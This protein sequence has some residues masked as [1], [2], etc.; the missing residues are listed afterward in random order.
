[1]RS[2]AAAHKHNRQLIGKT[3]DEPMLCIDRAC[4]KYTPRTENTLPLVCPF[5]LFDVIFGLFI[6]LGLLF[7]AIFL[8]GLRIFRLFSKNPR[9]LSRHLVRRSPL[10]NPCG[11]KTEVLTTADPRLIETLSVL[12]DK[13]K[14]V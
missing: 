10:I 2:C 11:T 4:K 9:N 8:W 12:R 3:K 1:M 5:E 7:F 13:T 14:T 6:F